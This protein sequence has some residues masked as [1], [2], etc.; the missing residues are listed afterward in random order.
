MSEMQPTDWSGKVI[1]AV[2]ALI[3]SAIAVVTGWLINRRKTKAETLSITSATHRTDASFDI[4]FSRE[5]RREMQDAT[6]QLSE[7][8]RIL[9]ASERC[10]HKCLRI[11]RQ[12]DCIPSSVCDQMEAEIN[13]IH[14]N[15]NA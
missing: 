12:G 5:I 4:E 15:F 10:L 8:Y 9:A 1:A 11:M 3:G 13:A 6:R 7:A 14:G 2:S